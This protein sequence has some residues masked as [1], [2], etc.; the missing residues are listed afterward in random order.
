[1]P[2]TTTPLAADPLVLWWQLGMKT[3]EMLLAS[4]QVIGIRVGRMA[5]AGS[6]PSAGDRKE[7]TRMVSEKVAAAG[8][9]GW[10]VAAQ[11][12]STWA[13]LWVRNWEQWL[14]GEAATAPRWDAH[15]AQL[16]HAAL[17]PVHR[18]ATANARRLAVVRARPAR[19]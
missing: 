16:A 19:R 10:G 17:R 13:Q 14:R 18:A 9:S 8:Q 11:L 7:F 2:K 1:M 5:A 6:R 15:A 12:Q 3:W 4:G